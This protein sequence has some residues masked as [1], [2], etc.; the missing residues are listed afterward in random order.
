MAEHADALSNR[1]P[2][3]SHDSLAWPGS[4]L[5]PEKLPVS[6]YVIEAFL[7]FEYLRLHH[8]LGLSFL[9]LPLIL[10]IGL[11]LVVVPRI[12]A[13]LSDRM[14]VAFG[15]LLIFMLF[16]VPLAVNNFSAL[17][18]LKDML[19]LL[20]VYA[21]ITEVVTTP[22]RLRHLI[23]VWLVIH[24]VLALYALT[25]GGSGPEGFVGDEND[26]ALIICMAVPYP[27][28]LLFAPTVSIKR[29]VLAVFLCSY[30]GTVFASNSRGGFLGLLVVSLYCLWKTPRKTLSIVTLTLCVLLGSMVA[31]PEYWERIN[32]IWGE[33]T[34]ELDGTGADRRWT[35][36][37]AQ[38][39]FL[40]N[41]IF[42]VGQGNFPWVI[43]EYEGAGFRERSFSGRAAHSVYFTL[44]PE[45]GVLGLVIFLYILRLLL[46]NL[47]FVS[48]CL[49]GPSGEAAS[50]T[51]ELLNLTY[52]CR[53]A[54]IGF[55]VSGAF[56]S[57]L[58]YPPFW[59]LLALSG[60]LKQVALD[61]SSDLAESQEPNS[62]PGPEPREKQE[63]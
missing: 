27:F 6:L 21:A 50:E 57:A 54:L 17:S 2:G 4:T 26:L 36:G 48:E 46:R 44:L 34:G 31:P 56:V 19:I 30:L 41:P 33:A 29:P 22:A 55:L 7:T 9:R 51:D 38:K 39:I 1:L 25:H 32:T 28:F 13:K 42:G 12:Q 40:G 23:W 37:I 3:T 5:V 60:S 20:I 24:F 35:W 47:R 16:H 62:Q 18:V 45:L 63:A 15:T 52:A 59:L 43:G 58:Y 14:F 53:A 8:V 10:S 11:A 61:I 49:R